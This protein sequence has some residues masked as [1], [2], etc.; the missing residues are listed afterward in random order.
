MTII[1]GMVNSNG[2]LSILGSAAAVAAIAWCVGM[3][4]GVV[5]L[6]SVNEH[7]EQHRRQH[8]IPDEHDPSGQADDPNS[9]GA[10]DVGR[11]AIG[12]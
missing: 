9:A 4:F 1:V 12:R 8:P 7:I 10:A 6:R 5:L 3:A 2:W 11:P